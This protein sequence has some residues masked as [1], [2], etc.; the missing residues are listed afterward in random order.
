MTL[1]LV[2]YM[3]LSAGTAGL[4][5]YLLMYLHYW[6]IKSSVEADSSLAQK[7]YQESERILSSMYTYTK[8]FVAL[9][10]KDK[11]NLI[12]IK[13]PESYWIQIQKHTNYSK[14]DVIGKS[15]KW[16]YVEIL[17]LNEN[18]IATRQSKILK[19]II[20][21]KPITYLENYKDPDG[22]RGWS[23]SSFI[24]LLDDK[25]EIDYILF[26][27][28]DVTKE[29]EVESE[30]RFNVTL[31]ESILD[32]SQFAIV[33]FKD[34][35][36]HQ[37][38]KTFTHYFDYQINEILGEPGE[39]IVPEKYYPL[40]HKVRQGL[41][42]DFKV[43]HL[44][45]EEEITLKRKDGSEFYC[46]VSVYPL[47]VEGTR[48]SVL[49]ISN[50]TEQRRIRHELEE[51]KEQLQSL[52]ENMPGMFFRLGTDSEFSLQYISG[53]SEA[54]LGIKNSDIKEKNLRG[55][56]V[57]PDEFITKSR[58]YLSQLMQTG[59]NGEMTLPIEY[60]SVKKWVNA[61]FKPTKLSSGERVI[62]GLLFDVTEQVLNEKNRK[63]AEESLRKN[64]SRLLALMANLP[65]MVY[66]SAH[67][68][69]FKLT[70]V[71]E[72]SL[73]LTGYT[74]DQLKTS[75][76]SIF[77][78]IKENYHDKIRR[79]V[80]EAIAEKKPYKLFYEIYTA[81]GPKWV[82]DRGQEIEK[83]YL[84][85]III[86]ITDRVESE[87]KIVQ[88][89][90][91][92]EDR[93]RKRIAKELHD[94]LGQKLT[95]VSLYFNSLKDKELEYNELN[96]RL[97]K[98]LGFLELAI[99]ETRNISHNLMPRNVEDF[100]LK[101]SIESLVNELNAIS[102][103]KFSFYDNLQDKDISVNL[104]LHL[105]R[106]TQEAINNVLKYAEA[107]Q[108]A[109]QLML[110]PDLIIWSIEDDGK[111]FDITQ[112]EK[113]QQFGLEGIRQR[114]QLLSGNATIES[115]INHGTSI[116]IE[117]PFKSHYVI[118]K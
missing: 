77:N 92:T 87:E 83:G 6:K 15:L 8:E 59:G 24:P 48:Y 82:F 108:V 45:L 55:R 38:N 50:I 118:E 19:T 60:S 33:L 52:I 101:L 99:K 90:I 5:V 69:D 113:E 12:I 3:F 7:K 39:I 29:K 117:I 62:D 75:K 61:R 58:E 111:G 32:Y 85:G 109:I 100:G 49:S 110:Y 17:K 36:I 103:T 40:L 64:Q 89:I 97:V 78:I 41:I 51:S 98:G 94:S 28:K 44:G 16:F 107:K 9:L 74:P 1:N 2:L 86:D 25:G 11:N 91:Q 104:G 102:E 47:P 20:E 18:E 37:I 35:K 81:A 105:Y 95:T 54:Y 4:L 106:I 27:S 84:E 96:T 10:K 56:D 30:L 73:E 116:T 112:L 76:S 53:N 66:R 31:L 67:K 68:N 114:A 13:F 71:S 57:L 79:D 34:G 88:T 42:N 93:E 70:F 23:N 21:R 65:G 46:E 80:A 115:R 26:T 22:K 63:K 43:F 72:G 14:E